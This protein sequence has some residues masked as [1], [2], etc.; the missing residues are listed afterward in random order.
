M[1]GSEV[2]TKLDLDGHE[3]DLPKLRGTDPVTSLDLPGEGLGPASAI[4]IASLIAGNEVLKSIDLRVNNLGD[5]GEEAI[6]DA[7]S[8]REGFKLE[9]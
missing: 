8:G 2:L 3:L 9:M 1:S 4:V 6:R 5:E 7:V